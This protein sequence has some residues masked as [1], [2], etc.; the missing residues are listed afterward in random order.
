MKRFKSAVDWWFWLLLIKVGLIGATIAA[1]LVVSEPTATMIGIVAGILFLAVA[2][3]L[4]ILAGTSYHV[5]ES[6]LL[7]K[8]GPFRWKV[9]LDQINSVRASS[10]AAASPALSLTRLEIRYDTDKQI[11]VSPADREGFLSAIG[12]RPET[13]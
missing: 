8:A 12:R 13:D 9:P 2:V 7:I 10:S 4:W 3:P 6:L 11:F 5:D 1:I